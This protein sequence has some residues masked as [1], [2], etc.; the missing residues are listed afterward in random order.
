VILG[1]PGVDTLNFGDAEDGDDEVSG[2]AGDDNLHAGVGRDRLFGNSGDDTLQE[3]EVDSPLVDLF[4]GGSGTD[5]CFAG[6]E[7]AVRS[8]EVTS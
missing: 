1:G 8:C 6:A 4:S 5:T 2:G 7:D 3:G